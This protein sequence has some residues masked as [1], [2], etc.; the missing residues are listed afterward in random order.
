LP[1]PDPEIDV[2]G[3]AIY[4]ALAFLAGTLL[5]SLA[6][7]GRGPEQGE[8]DPSG[9][10]PE[11]LDR[12][13]VPAIEWIPSD[14]AI[15]APEVRQVKTGDDFQTE[16]IRSLRSEVDAMRARIASLENRL[17]DLHA[18]DASSRNEQTHAGVDDD[19]QANSDGDGPTVAGLID[20]GVS[21]DTAGEIVRRQ[22]EREMRRL[23]LRDRAAREGYLGTERF[24]DELRELNTD[25]PSLRQEIGESGYDRYLFS[26]GQDNRVSVTSVI[27][28]S[29]A[30]QAGI[31]PGD[32]ILSY[33]GSRIFD[34]S[35]LQGATRGGE[36]DAPVSVQIRRGTE[37]IAVSIPRGPMGVR[38]EPAREDPQ[39]G[40]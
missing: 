37:R 32:V 31:R 5:G 28:G 3:S 12:A 34:F 2:K 1:L 25:T 26:A 30:E 33:D 20:A 8:P 4:L 17:A 21:P 39:G 38:L 19:Q 27:A 6:L 9:G 15:E 16:R 35:E 36:R 29:P 18:A 23:E 22:G 24:F 40:L 14:A 10:A 11:A 13:P 7:G